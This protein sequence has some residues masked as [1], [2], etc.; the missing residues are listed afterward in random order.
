MSDSNENM[1]EFISGQ[2]TATITF[3]D[4]PHIRKI[5][6][7]Y[8]EHPEDF[9]Y[10]IKN[11][12]GSIC[13]KVPLKWVKVSPP[14]KTNREYTDEERQAIADRLALYRNNRLKGK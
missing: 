3:T 14:R 11:K 6:K 1:I 5:E 9:T 2:R 10:F 12:D 13:F 8:K 4:A 7:I